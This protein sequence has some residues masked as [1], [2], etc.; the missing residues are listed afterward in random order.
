M[1]QYAYFAVAS[2]TMTAQEM[3]AHLGLEPDRVAVRGSIVTDPPRPGRHRWEI[4]NVTRGLD[5]EDL[6]APILERV[7]PV[8]SKVRELVD[9]DIAW[10]KLQIVRYLDDEAGVEEEITTTHHDGHV[11]QKSPGQHQMLGWGLEPAALEL[12]VTMRAYLDVDEYNWPMTS[13]Y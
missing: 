10:A 5:V 13:E 8:A 4:Q 11:L 9:D 12:L 2:R 6:I 7:A 3:S 1:N